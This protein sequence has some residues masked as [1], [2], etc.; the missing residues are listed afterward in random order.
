[1][2]NFYFECSIRYDKTM[3]TGLIKKVTEK[4]LVEALSF[5]EAEARFAEYMASY[6][7]GEYDICAIRRLNIAE[8]FMSKDS[9]ACRWFRAKLAYIIPDERTGREKKIPSIVY[10]LAKDFDDARNVIQESMRDTLGDWE[11][12]VLQE[13]PIIKLIQYTH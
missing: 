7:S 13:T 6:I 9:D 1:M 8:V 4:Y 2:K 11:K 3:E 12:A 10:V 5:A